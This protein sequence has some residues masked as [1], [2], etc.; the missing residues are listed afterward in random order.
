M[1]LEKDGSI[2]T[3]TF[4]RTVDVVVELCEKYG[5]NQHDLYRHYDVTAKNC[6]ASFVAR[7]SDWTRFKNEVARKLKGD[8]T[9]DKFYTYTPDRVVTLQEI[10][11]YE[12]VTLKKTIKRYAEGT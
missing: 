5:L 11:L 7:P 4:N 3:T 8:T 2:A 1:C 9:S 10:G 12:D 6:P